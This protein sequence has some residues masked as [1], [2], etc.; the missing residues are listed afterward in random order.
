V[1]VV[2]RPLMNARIAC[3]GCLQLVFASESGACPHCDRRLVSSVPPEPPLTGRYS[4]RFA[5]RGHPIMM[6]SDQVAEAYRWYTDHGLSLRR[7]AE[8]LWPDTGYASPKSCAAMLAEQWRIRDWPLRDRIAATVTASYRHGKA[9]D[10]VHRRR[11]RKARGEIRGV[12]C[13][14]TKTTSPQLGRPCQRAAL[15]DSQYCHSHDPRFAEAREATLEL[16]R[17]A[18][19]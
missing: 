15:A 11:Q 12:Q 8:R 9:R 4:K 18:I 13:A 1:S 3:P 19:S 14:G 16:A 7:C 2:E 10:P 5:T 6:S 17:A